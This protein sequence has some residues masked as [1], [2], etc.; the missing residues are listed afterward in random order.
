MLDAQAHARGGDLTAAQDRLDE[1]GQ[2]LYRILQDAGEA[3]YWRVLTSGGASPRQIDAAAPDGEALS[4]RVAGWVVREQ[5]ALDDAMPVLWADRPGSINGWSMV[6]MDRL[7][8][9]AVR[10]AAA[11]PACE[12]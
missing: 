4:L 7:R 6:A 11:G 12:W 9:L 3:R 8:R 1:L 5:E 10:R 2:A